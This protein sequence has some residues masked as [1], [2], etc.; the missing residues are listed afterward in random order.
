MSTP[1]SVKPILYQGNNIGNLCPGKYGGTQSA[2]L[3]LSNKVIAVAIQEIQTAEKKD[4]ELFHKIFQLFREARH[5]IA[6]EQKTPNHQNFGQL[7]TV[8]G[9]PVSNTPLVHEYAQAGVSL[10]KKVMIPLLADILA[11]KMNGKGD[12]TCQI[13]GTLIPIPDEKKSEALIPKLHDN[14]AISRAV[15]KLRS[16]NPSEYQQIKEYMTAQEY[17]MSL[18]V[19]ESSPIDLFRSNV[20]MLAA[21]VHVMVAN[22]MTQIAEFIT[23]YRKDKPDNLTDFVQINHLHAENIDLMLDDIADIFVRIVTCDQ[24]EKRDLAEFRYKFAYCMP[25][26]NG[27]AAIA[28][29]FE[30]TL[31]AIHKERIIIPQNIAVDL[32]AFGNPYFPHF[33]KAYEKNVQLEKI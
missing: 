27:S 1:A 32:L 24:L 14:E 15:E 7:R 18:I 26:L 5:S 23:L 9:G 8:D 25:C 28:E 33:V 6:K 17:Q 19:F 21:S 2:Y 22:K 3:E 30:V 12:E 20:Q 11:K 10:R 4:K 16:T 31:A 29:W 13:K